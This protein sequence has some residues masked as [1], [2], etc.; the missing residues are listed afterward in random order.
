MAE[1]GFRGVAWRTTVWHSQIFESAP[2]SVSK[3]S[4]IIRLEGATFAGCKVMKASLFW[5]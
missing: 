4:R 2:T 1:L 3:M 5:K